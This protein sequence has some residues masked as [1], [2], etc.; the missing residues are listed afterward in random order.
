[1]K[2]IFIHFADGFEEIEALAPVDILRRAG[3]DVTIVSMMGRKEVTSSRGV[4]IV[5]DK[6]FEEMIY[7]EADMLVLP[8]G[9]PG[10]KN[11]DEHHGLKDKIVEANKS[12]KWIAAICAAPMVLGHL[13]LL[14]GKKATCYPGNEPDLVGATV[15]GAPVE[16]DGNIITAKGAGV[17]VK[18]GLALAEVLVGKEKAD[19]IKAKMMVE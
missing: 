2:K 12:G 8:G 11:L 17:S 19:E 13:G 6:L 14:K 7:A 1:M 3:C 9:M 4:K 18:F 15:T 16:K 10:S 5:A